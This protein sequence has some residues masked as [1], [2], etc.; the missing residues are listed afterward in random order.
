M[1][2]KLEKKQVTQYSKD[3]ILQSARFANRKDAL[4]V[5]LKDGKSYSLS[6]IDSLYERFMKGRVK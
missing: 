5:I 1:S 4:S 6:E 3:Q 2:A